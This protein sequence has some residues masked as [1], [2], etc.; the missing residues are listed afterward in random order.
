MKDLTLGSIMKVQ[1]SLYLFLIQSYTHQTN[2]V[3]QFLGVVI[4]NHKQIRLHGTW[5][6]QILL[7]ACMQTPA[8][9]HMQQESLFANSLA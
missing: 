9:L 1:P 8:A 6:L 3:S 2:L 7:H 5:C 4:F